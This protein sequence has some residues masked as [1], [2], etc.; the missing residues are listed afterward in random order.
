MKKKDSNLD[1]SKV[2]PEV[3]AYFESLVGIDIDDAKKKLGHK[4]VLADRA[5]V[6]ESGWYKFER[7]LA[8]TI[9]LHTEN[10]IVTSEYHNI[11]ACVYAK[12]NINS[13]SSR[14]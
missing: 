7:S 5:I 13:T 10:N 1:E 3:K 2:E 12:E 11:I 9:E 4:W 8:G 14:D 6:G